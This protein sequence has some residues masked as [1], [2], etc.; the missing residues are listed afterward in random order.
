LQDQLNN[1]LKGKSHFAL[2]VDEFGE[3]EGL[4]TLEDILEEIVGDI[5]D[6]YDEVHEGARKQADGS[7]LIDGAK[8]I[9]DVN[10]LLD[11]NLPD[12]EATTIAGL[13]LHEAKMIPS[14]NQSFNFHGFRFRVT[15]KVHNRITEL[16]VSKS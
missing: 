4:V 7:Y 13:I 6:E 10:R 12:D 16:R 14:V 3:V 8:P 15:K 5:S 1:F 2:V 9:R 11:W